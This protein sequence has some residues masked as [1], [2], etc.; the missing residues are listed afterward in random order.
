MWHCQNNWFVKDIEVGHHHSGQKKAL[1]EKE[2]VMAD[3]G[4]NVNTYISNFVLFNSFY[5]VHTYI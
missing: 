3:S 5:F 2:D 4:V 1:Q